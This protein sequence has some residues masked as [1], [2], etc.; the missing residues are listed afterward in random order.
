[1]MALSHIATAHLR[2]PAPVAFDFL[3]DPMRLG[4]WSLGCMDTEPADMPGVYKGRSLFDGTSGWFHIVADAASGRI[5][6]HVGSEAERRPRIEA[7]VVPGAD[8]E[9]APDTCYVSLIAWRTA[10]MDDARWHRL[11]TAHEAEILLIRS[12]CE[13]ASP[14]GSGRTIGSDERKRM[15]SIGVDSK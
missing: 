15:R 12:Q 11:T 13:A 8:C 1:M 7:R 10:S 5:V 2:V 9:Q 3:S 14:Y 6:Y 4:R